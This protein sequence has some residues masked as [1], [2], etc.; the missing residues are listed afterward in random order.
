M[1]ETLATGKAG[2]LKVLKI[3][4]D[5]APAVSQRFE[6]PANSTLIV[7]R[8]RQVVARQVRA[9]PRPW[10]DDALTRQVAS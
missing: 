5:D 8:G 4:A 3:S 1:L 9:A 6:A 7:L 2:E 10:L